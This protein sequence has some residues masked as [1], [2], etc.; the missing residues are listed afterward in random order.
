[1]PTCNIDHINCTSAVAFY[2][3]MLINDYGCKVAV[4]RKLVGITINTAIFTVSGC[5]KEKFPAFLSVLAGIVPA[6]T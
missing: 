2:S 5:T 3:K 4:Q 1:M 6:S